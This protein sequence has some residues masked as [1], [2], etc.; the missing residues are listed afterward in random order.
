MSNKAEMEAYQALLAFRDARA[1]GA[2]GLAESQLFQSKLGQVDNFER[3]TELQHIFTAMNFA[4]AD[5]V[6][7]AFGKAAKGFAELKDAFEISKKMAENGKEDLFFP[8]VAAELS[9]IAS[10]IKAIKEA[11]DTLKTKTESLSEAFQ[12][13]DAQTLIN[14][15]ILAKDDIQNLLNALND[16]KQALPG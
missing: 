12:K 3:K 14:E 7:D 8:S 4:Q 15:A 16:L 13:E 9:T 1:A 2:N 10:T 11:T 6:F 5:K